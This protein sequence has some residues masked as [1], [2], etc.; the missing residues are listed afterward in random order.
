MTKQHHINNAWQP[1]S[2]GGA[3]PVIDPS[4]GETF[5]EIARGAAADVSSAV[6]AA[7]AAVGDS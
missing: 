7:R 3:I 1:A 5:G 4:T 2:G 6:A